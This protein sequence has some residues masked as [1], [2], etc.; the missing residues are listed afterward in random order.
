MTVL[1]EPS[2]LHT[3]GRL[4][5]SGRGG[6]GNYHRLAAAPLPPPPTTIT[7]QPSTRFFSGRGGTGNAHLFGERAMFSFD[8]ELERDRLMQE[9]HAPVFSVGRGGAGNIVAASTRSSADSECSSMRSSG[10]S[11]RSNNSIRHAADRVLNRISRIRSSGS[12]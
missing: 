3:A 12:Q 10:D 8:E 6:A 1:A 5:Q 4:Y 11:V 9:K 2:P 7:A